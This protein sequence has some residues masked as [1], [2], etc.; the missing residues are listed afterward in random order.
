ME[1]FIRQGPTYEDTRRGGSIVG[2]R[3]ISKSGDVVGRVMQLRIDPDKRT[4]EGVVVRRKLFRTLYICMSY[5]TRI[6]DKALMLAIDP[7]ALFKGRAVVS[8]DGKKFGTVAM[9]ERAG[10]TNEVVRVIVRRHL[11][12]KIAIPKESFSRFGTSL[13]L[14][15][16]Y[17]KARKE[18]TA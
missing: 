3:V 7:A 1:S 17:D 2:K 15:D 12:K 10:E 9:L 13:I 6:T 16:T 14:K 18:Y 11:Y 5:V 4:L 8:S